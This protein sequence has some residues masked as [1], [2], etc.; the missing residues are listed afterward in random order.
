[1]ITWI[2]EETARQAAREGLPAATRCSW[3]KWWNYANCTQEEL[4][5]AIKGKLRVD[6]N[7]AHYVFTTKTNMETN[8]VR[9]AFWIAVVFSGTLFG[10]EPIWRC[11][12]LET[13]APKPTSP[14][15]S[16]KPKN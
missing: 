5:G 10:N 11:V 12:I 1:M 9:N 16:K 8:S 13:T 3:Q 15:S 6:F 4:E 14:P 7:A 2:T